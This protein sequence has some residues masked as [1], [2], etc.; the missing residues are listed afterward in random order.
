[1]EAFLNQSY[2]GM[3]HKWKNAFS[4]N[5]EDALTWSCFDLIA[6]FPGLDKAIAL[7]EILEDAYAGS[8]PLSFNSRRIDNENIVG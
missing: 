4:S 1:M 2:E 6:N 3:Q 8:S 5:S 7:D